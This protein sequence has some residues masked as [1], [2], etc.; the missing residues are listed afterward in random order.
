MTKYPAWF[1]VNVRLGHERAV[2]QRLRLK[3]VEEFLPLFRSR[4]R[5]SAPVNPVQVPLFGGYVFCRL[6]SNNWLPILKTP[7]VRSIVSVR[8]I[9]VAVPDQE[10]SA[11]QTIAGSGL[12]VRPWPYIRT[13]QVVQVKSGSLAGL[14]AILVREEDLRILV[15]VD[16]LKRSIVVSI[17]REMICAVDGAAYAPTAQLYLTA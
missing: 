6:S 4:H 14:K 11:L 13:G 16:L 3:G 10:I 5:G 9:P 8:H 1:A 7:G 17:D 15:S 12:P 2:S